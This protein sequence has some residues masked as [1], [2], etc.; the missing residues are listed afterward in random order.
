MILFT[1]NI[2]NI[3]NF[4]FVFLIIASSFSTIQSLLKLAMPRWAFEYVVSSPGLY[5]L[6][7]C[8]RREVVD[9]LKQYLTSEA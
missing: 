5:I 3:S 9:S 2:Y 1:T 8:V 6:D 7:V 4:H